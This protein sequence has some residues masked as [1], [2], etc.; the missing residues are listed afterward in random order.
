M[1]DFF[2]LMFFFLLY[3]VTENQC[4]FSPFIVGKHLLLK[5]R[6]PYRG[7]YSITAKRSTPLPW[8][9]ILAIKLNALL[10]SD[11]FGDF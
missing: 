5:P 6:G 11:I 9:P 7:Y 1:N 10:F 3:I 8:Q 4:F 2:T